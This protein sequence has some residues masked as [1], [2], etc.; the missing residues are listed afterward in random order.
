M[1]STFKMSG[2]DAFFYIMNVGFDELAGSCYNFVM[3]KKNL[4]CIKCCTK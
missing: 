4:S 2:F 1:I 3:I